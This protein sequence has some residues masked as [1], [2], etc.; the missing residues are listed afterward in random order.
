M[1]KLLYPLAFA[2]SAFLFVYS[3]STEEDDAP[4]PDAIVKKYILAVTAGEGGTVSSSGGTYSQGTQVSITATPS[5]GYKFSGWSN[6]STN[7]PILVNLNSNQN[8]TANFTQIIIS[9]IDINSDVDGIVMGDVLNISTIVY[10]QNDNEVENFFPD[11]SLSN[12]LAHLDGNN[13]ITEYDGEVTLYAVI[14][15]VIDSVKI[16]ILPDFNNWKTYYRPLEEGPYDLAY[17]YNELPGNIFN[18][19]S[20]KLDYDND[21][22]EELFLH[23]H[24]GLRNNIGETSYDDVPNKLISFELEGDNFIDNSFKVFGKSSID[25]NQSNSRMS[26]VSDLNGDGIKDVFFALNK[27]D[28]RG[29]PY[30]TWYSK[31]LL[32]LSNPSGTFQKFEFGYSSYYHGVDIVNL[33]NNV[34][35]LLGS[36][37][38]YNTNLNFSEPHL[39]LYNNGQ[40]NDHKLNLRWDGM[41]AANYKDSND[42]IFIAASEH[43]YSFNEDGLE[44]SRPRI[45]FYKLSGLNNI[46]LLDTHSFDIGPKIRYI[47]WTGIETE[48]NTTIIDGL[49]F[50][51]GDLY[52]TKSLKL[53]PDSNPIFITKFSSNYFDEEIDSTKLYN[54]ANFPP[55]QKLVAYQIDQKASLLSI[56]PNNGMFLENINFME[57]IDLNNDGYEDLALYPYKNESKPIV[58]FNNL[59]GAFNI[60]PDNKFPNQDVNGYSSTAL[61]IDLNGDRIQDLIYRSGNQ[62]NPNDPNQSNCDKLYV[63]IGRRV[64]SME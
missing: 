49:N 57:A 23:Y 55:A 1:K 8:L 44:Y 58:L 60:M 21:G 4:P 25:L 64:L 31:P 3:C 51:A 22:R 59:N 18:T 9:K 6:G 29:E 10:D 36:D 16:N 13:L 63:F 61:F 35:I 37:G 14:E 15:D 42:N 38:Y 54:T 56:F 50:T 53:Y 12:D 26:S 17:I 47:D 34:A 40:V 30:E 46:T 11:F 52:E 20:A 19:V 43:D 32:L 41:T 33:E 45:N 5:S 7:N 2:L 28:G 24:R 62:C 48:R 27:E 39:Y